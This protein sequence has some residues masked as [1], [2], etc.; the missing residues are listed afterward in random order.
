VRPAPCLLFVA[1]VVAG[2]VAVAPGAAGAR[3]R[4]ASAAPVLVRSGPVSL[5]GGACPSGA[6]RARVAI[7]RSVLGRGQV[8]AVTATV[9]NVGSVACGYEGRPSGP[10]SLGPCGMLSLSVTSATGTAVWPG[11]GRFSCPMLVQETLAPGTS[12]VATGVWDQQN[13]LNARPPRG[14]YRLVVAGSLRFDLTL[15]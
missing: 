15:R 1:A 14:R 10:P 7:S 11:T 13:A 5:G 3:P 4:P 6:L 9:S 8:L 12:V 2:A